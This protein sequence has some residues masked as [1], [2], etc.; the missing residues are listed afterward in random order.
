[1]AAAPDDMSAWGL[2]LTHGAVY[3]ADLPPQN[4]NGAFSFGGLSLCPQSFRVALSVP[5]PR[6]TVHIL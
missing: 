2:C 4:T 5:A 1:M 6:H 3:L